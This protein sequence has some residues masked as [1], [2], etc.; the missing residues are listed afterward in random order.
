MADRIFRVFLAKVA[1][2]L[3][4]CAGMA[5]A[6]ESYLSDLISRAKAT[7]L[8][9]DDQWL[10]LLHYKPSLILRRWSS[11]IDEPGFFLDVNGK[12][13]PIAELEATLRAFFSTDKLA[14]DSQPARC[15][16]VARYHWLKLKLHIDES[17]LPAVECTA[18]E[19]W[20]SALDPRSITLVFPEAFLNNPASTF[21]HT[22][23]RID[24]GSQTADTSLLAYAAT[25]AANTA[26]EGALLYAFK[27][28]FGGYTGYFSVLPYYK[29]VNQYSAIESRDIWEYSLTLNLEETRFLVM[30][31]WELLNV[32]IQYYYF[33][34]NCSYQL[35]SLIE[36]A[37]PD[38]RLSQKF[39]LWVI[40]VD[41]VRAVV[42][43]P[44]LV[45][46]VNFRP[47]PQTVL[48]K[49]LESTNSSEQFVA[50][51]L[52]DTS[53]PIELTS[54]ESLPFNSQAHALDLGYD[55]LN[56]KRI[57]GRTSNDDADRRM[58]QL[59]SARSKVET[60]P[61]KL[62][63]PT[64]EVHPEN[65]HR[66]LRASIRLGR[67]DERNFYELS[68]RPAYHDLLD[69]QAGFAGGAQIEMLQTNLR[70]YESSS[71]KFERF[72]PISILSLSPRNS[73]V[74][75]I[76]YRINTEIGRKHFDSDRDL[77]TRIN[78]GPGFSWSVGANDLAYLMLENS[79]EYSHSYDQD[80]SI[81]AGANIGMFFDLTE[82]WRIQPSFDILRYALGDEHTEVGAKIEQRFTLESNLTLRFAIERK[83]EIDFYANSL[84]LG[85]DFYL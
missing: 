6:E 26:G 60:P 35:L 9:E 12:Y 13:D 23:L 15:V 19:Q 24:S 14:R 70:Q 72:S 46:A 20:F 22:L 55:Y 81:G 76:S 78:G 73:L 67:D 10:A 75:P 18:F 31:I 69:P 49:R 45:G 30:H 77:V 71:L 48:S 7:K 63:I 51:D 64:P 56:Y 40:P 47:S 17:K 84:F 50:Q 21:G 11:L 74:K 43:T 44:G 28:L 1:F 25:Y 36:V 82:R 38:L 79:F 66:S 2:T 68:L 58:L 5:C 33:D 3:L 4:F 59:L 62:V 32:N 52:A 8:E 53:K 65:G 57:S 39:K 34:E 16:F 54:L 83:Q 27:G 41:T 37:R 61:D 42:E 85:V 80:Y 29:K